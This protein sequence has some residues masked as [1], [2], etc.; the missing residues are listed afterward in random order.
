MPKAES[1]PELPLR[2]LVGPLVD[3]EQIGK[4]I[5]HPQIRSLYDPRIVTQP[6][7]WQGLIATETSANLPWKAYSYGESLSETLNKWKD[8]QPQLILWWGFAYNVLP[9]E[10]HQAPCPVILIAS[11]WQSCGSELWAWRE[12]FDFI[13]AD[14][15]LVNLFQ[16]RGF[17]RCGYWP[18]YGFSPRQFYPKIDQTKKWDLSY[19]GSFNPDTHPERLRL[20][21]QLAPLAN[22]FRIC[23]REKVYGSE[24]LSILQDSKVV[25]NHA[26]RGEMNLRAYQA[27]ASGA[28]LFQEAENLE[29][30]KF[31]IP[32]KS[33]ILYRSE[34]LLCQA[35]H[36]LNRSD[37]ANLALEGQR[38]IQPHSY[39][40]QFEQ[41]LNELPILLHNFKRPGADTL[42]NVS[43]ARQLRQALHPAFT[44]GAQSCL[45]KIIRQEEDFKTFELRYLKSS[46]KIHL[47]QSA[48]QAWTDLLKLS[49][50]KLPSSVF[51]HNLAWASYWAKQPYSEVKNRAQSARMQLS[52]APHLDQP[53]LDW[54]YPWLSAESFQLAFASA[55][56]Q[57]QN[58]HTLLIWNLWR[59]EAEAALAAALY[60]E[61]FLALEAASLLKNCPP[62]LWYPQAQIALA[63]GLW[64]EAQTA[65]EQTLKYYPLFKAAWLMQV[66]LIIQTPTRH[67]LE[68][69][70]YIELLKNMMHLTKVIPDWAENRNMCKI[71]LKDLA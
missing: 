37:I 23:F 6:Q 33:C 29:I 19:I 51:L 41:L 61:A 45:Q 49:Q 64:Q 59:L 55:R 26:L 70:K 31:L 62:T 18:S 16:S 46:L 52:T 67:R 20:L 60:S 21:S 17:K 63:L 12:V 9:I 5:W 8:W 47:K 7:A 50:E 25:F 44:T 22:D 36:L 28:L 58:L 71:L 4:W 66:K 39:E 38:A 32:D 65:L 13:L 54:V 40:H 35:K 1:W 68:K 11:D 24:Y 14:Q 42:R 53:E 3:P 2:I 48:K 34:D 56:V 43:A 69:L 30:T 27:V 15:A 10:L 57:E